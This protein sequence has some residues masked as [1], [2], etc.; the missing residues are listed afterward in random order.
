MQNGIPANYTH[1]LDAGGL[2]GARIGVLR[3]LSN[4][5][6]ADPE[7]LGIFNGALAR[8]AQQGTCTRAVF[9]CTFSIG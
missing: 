4:T 3:Q 5:P 7:L 9:P 2:V 6:T 1:F 8:M